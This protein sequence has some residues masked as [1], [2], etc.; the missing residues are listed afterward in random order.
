MDSVKTC[1]CAIASKECD[2]LHVVRSILCLLLLAS[3]AATIPASRVA[4]QEATPD[5]SPL[6][7]AAEGVFT[8]TIDIGG[9]ALFLTCQGKGA[10]TVVIDHGQWGS[11]HD[12]LPFQYAL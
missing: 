5:A 7:S 6:P 2:M 8:R 4:A 3:T 9:R 11:S 1:S 10:P 12:M